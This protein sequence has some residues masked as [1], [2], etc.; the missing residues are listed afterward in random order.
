MEVKHCA[1]EPT[2]MTLNGHA[3]YSEFPTGAWIRLRKGRIRRWARD[4]RSRNW[5]LS[6]APQM[7]SNLRGCFVIDVVHHDAHHHRRDP[8]SQHHERRQ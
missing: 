1:R 6:S 5:Q 8:D 3:A 2:W 7:P 4:P